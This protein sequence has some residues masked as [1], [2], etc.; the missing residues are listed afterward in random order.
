MVYVPMRTIH[1]QIHLSFTNKE[2]KVS[3]L[4]GIFTYADNTQSDSIRYIGEIMFKHK[5]SIYN[6]PPQLY[7]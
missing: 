1:S 3:K 7:E 4:Y 5:F 6:L 2:I